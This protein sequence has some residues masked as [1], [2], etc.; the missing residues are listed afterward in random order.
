MGTPEFHFVS[1]FLCQRCVC[2]AHRVTRGLWWLTSAASQHATA[3]TLSNTAVLQAS[4]SAASGFLVMKNVKGSRMC[5]LAHSDRV[6]H[7]PTHDSTVLVKP[8]SG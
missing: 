4:I 6:R 8:S 5:I 7:T 1:G 3:V 2:E